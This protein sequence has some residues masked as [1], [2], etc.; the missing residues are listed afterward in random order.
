MASVEK[1]QFW[2]PNFDIN[3]KVITQEIQYYLGPEATV[4]PYTHSVGGLD[5]PPHQSCWLDFKGEDG[6]LITTLGECLTDV[7]T[8]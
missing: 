2:I 7:S 3:K 6:F 8:T 4:R 5:F 1:N